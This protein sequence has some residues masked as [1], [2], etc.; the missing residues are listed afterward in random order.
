[1]KLNKMAFALAGLM[2][3]VSGTAGAQIILNGP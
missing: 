2:F 3:A 1:M